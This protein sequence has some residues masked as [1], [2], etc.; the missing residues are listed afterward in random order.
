[1]Q[2]GEMGTKGARKIKATK[3]CNCYIMQS[4]FYLCR[5]SK[6]YH[7]DNEELPKVFGKDTYL[8]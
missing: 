7:T 1:M 4:L 6:L 8:S 3:V 5:N 2:I